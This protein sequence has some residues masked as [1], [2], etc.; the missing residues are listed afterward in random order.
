MAGNMVD[1]HGENT[2][3]KGITLAIRF[4]SLNICRFLGNCICIFENDQF[5]LEP[6][7]S[8]LNGGV[9]ECGAG[10]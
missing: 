10:E 7:Y 1:P 6:C 3:C 5:K 4:S 8:E 2:A 9:L